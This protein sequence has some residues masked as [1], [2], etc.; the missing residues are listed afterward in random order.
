MIKQH[1]K[2]L[3]ENSDGLI[4]FL[5]GLHYLVFLIHENPSTDENYNSDALSQ[6]IEDKEIINILSYNIYSKKVLELYSE[7]SLKSL[8]KQIEKSEMSSFSN[9]TDV[10]FEGLRREKNELQEKLEFA[11][12][13]ED[14]IAELNE[15][16][17]YAKI[18]GLLEHVEKMK[19]KREKAHYK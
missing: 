15:A 12:N 6:F 3:Y 8:I 14:Q 4:K 11:V 19:I 13:N 7:V 17:E 10:N 2:T 9:D 16:I 5:I 18:N 1:L